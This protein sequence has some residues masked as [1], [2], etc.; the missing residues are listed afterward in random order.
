MCNADVLRMC[1]LLPIHIELAIQRLHFLQS[2]IRYKSR[3][4]AYLTAMFGIYVFESSCVLFARNP[5]PSSS[6]RARVRGVVP[7]CENVLSVGQVKTVCGPSEDRVG[8]QTEWKEMSILLLRCVY[9]GRAGAKC[10]WKC[11]G[12][13]E[14]TKTVCI[15]CVSGLGDVGSKN[16]DL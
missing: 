9:G 13:G 8:G 6:A 4:D 3:H 7:C 16:C 14:A 2:V 15:C 10:A 5:C 1:G 12:D 11:V